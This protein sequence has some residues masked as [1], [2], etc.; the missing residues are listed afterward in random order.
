MN[1]IYLFCNFRSGTFDND[2][3]LIRF[4]LKLE[5]TESVQAVDLPPANL[6]PENSSTFFQFELSYIVSQKI[7]SIICQR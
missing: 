2:I 5:K 3:A 7:T 4:V 1:F 6:A